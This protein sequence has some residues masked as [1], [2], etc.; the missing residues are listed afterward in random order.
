M[1]KLLGASKVSDETS[2]SS[3]NERSQ[4]VL[5]SS[6]AMLAAL[7]EGIEMEAAISQAELRT[8]CVLCRATHLTWEAAKTGVIKCGSCPML[9]RQ[10]ETKEIKS[11]L[12]VNGCFVVQLFDPALQ[13]DRCGRT[14]FVACVVCPR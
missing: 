8:V 1:G 7:A 12:T 13:H 5:L 10:A 11:R 6:C 3:S 14:R 4:L 9:L 2:K